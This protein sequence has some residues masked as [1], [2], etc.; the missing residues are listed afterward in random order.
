MRL[1]RI[2]HR[3]SVVAVFV[4]LAGYT[5]T[6]PAVA[7]AA[8][9]SGDPAWRFLA[10]RYDRNG[11]GQ[12]R[13]D[14]YDRGSDAFRALDRD[15]DGAITAA[16]F[17]LPVIMPTEL[18]TPF[19]LIRMF[20]DPGAAQL[21][22]EDLP[23][24]FLRADRD[25]DGKLTRADMGPAAAA[26]RAG[27]TDSFGSLLAALDAN[28]DGAITVEEALAGFDRR[29][30]NRDGIML[31]RE[32]ATEGREPPVGA[33]AAEDREMAPD[34]ELAPEAGGEPVRLSS[35]RGKRPVALIFGSFT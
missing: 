12:V 11:D 21:R 9:A 17:D 13:A 7:P 27:A 32:R 19:L 30:V 26:P 6:P 31:P 18:A 22:R 10:Q 2:P 20:G 8:S 14:E 4:I 29:D 16:D 28:H 3:R 34:F 25:H 33:I 1:A 5:S 24:G 35:L 23:T 15:G